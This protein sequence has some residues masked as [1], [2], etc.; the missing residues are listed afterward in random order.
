MSH[1]FGRGARLSTR[2]E[3]TAVQE[4]GRRVSGRF[5]TLLGRPNGRGSDRL[6]IIASRRIGGAV[7]R[8]RAKRRLR[9]IFRREAPEAMGDSRPAIDFVAIARRD[10]AR[11]PF[12]DVD[13]DVRATLRRL[14]N[15]LR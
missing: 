4:G 7:V 3:Y 6:G 15:A 8:N 12:A 5:L 13:A 14:R 10:L 1:T 11:A 9:E 2:A